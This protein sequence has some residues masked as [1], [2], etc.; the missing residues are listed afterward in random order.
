MT[1]PATTTD[2]AERP[3]ALTFPT[4]RPRLGPATARAQRR[5]LAGYALLWVAGLLPALLGAAPAATAAGLGLLWPGAGLAATGHPWWTLT[6]LVAMLLA[7]VT[8]WFAGPVVLPVAVWLAAAGG[9]AA[10]AGPGP[11]PT[12][13]VVAVAAVVPVV[14]AVAVAVHAL[15]HARQVRE[16][17]R[18]DA[19]LAAARF[20]VPGPPELRTGGL[21]VAEHTA[22]DLARLRC[23]LDLMLQPL[24]RFDGFTVIDQYREAA[25]RYQLN[26]GV[27]ALAMSQ[28]TRTPAFGGYLAEAQRNGITKMLDR[29]VW[30]YWATENAWG[31]LSLRRDP[32]DNREN[33][34]LTGFHGV[35][36]GMYGS[37]NDDRFAAPGALTY[38]WNDREAY[39]NDFGT[40]AGSVHRNM[41][42]SP[43][44]LY[45]CEPNWIYT[46]CNTFGLNTLLLHDRLHGTGYADGPD[47][48]RARLARAYDTEFTRPDGRVVGVRAGLLGLSWNFWAGASVQ[49][50]TTYWMHAG[51]PEIALRTWW[52]LRERSLTLRDGRLALPRGTAG[53]RLDP[54]DYTLGRDTFG[55]VATTMAAREV[56]DEE[57]AAAAQATLDEREPIARSGGAARFAEASTLVSMYALLGRNGRRSGLRDLVLHGAPDTWAHGPRLADA[58]YPDVLVAR[59]VTDGAAL[60]LVLRAGR[61]D[62]RVRLGLERLRPG[63]HYVLTGAVATDATAGP[64]GT[65]QIE[66]DL[67][68]R[69]VVRV[70][71]A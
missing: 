13:A 38:R 22:E 32:V 42:R 68:E 33:V 55:L 14:V 21:P 64:D 43:F 28:Y 11:V 46:I 15:R 48:V 67:G 31:N 60:E 17:R 30:G 24:D 26:A 50:N 69:T 70:H 34:M 12:G 8:W 25:L 59:A 44:T 7:L 10:V 37:L 54:G 23:A 40:L 6:A 58:A 19:E 1:S 41:S 20:T 65:L 63:G 5:A 18:L 49:L 71:P 35:M 29:R 62:R 51:M 66:V 52:L 57:Y 61:G 53:D 2:P 39:P 56:G 4:D 27:Y 47:G 16:G 9:A 3:V 45:A 36:T